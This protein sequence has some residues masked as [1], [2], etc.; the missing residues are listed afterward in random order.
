MSRYLPENGFR[1]YSGDH[2][3]SH[4]SNLLE[5]LSHES[6]TGMF[7]EVD[8]LYPK[9]LH[10][11]HNDLPYLAERSVPEGSK[12]SKLMTTLQPKNNY[13]V[14]YLALKQAMEAGLILNKVCYIIHT[15]NIQV[16]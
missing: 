3:V 2:S 1:W 11:A 6:S 16:Y 13:I 4:I 12:I 9:E 8:L 7:L 5:S 15:F 14:H 10:D